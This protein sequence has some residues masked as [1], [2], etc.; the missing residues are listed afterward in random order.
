MPA[1]DICVASRSTM[2]NDIED[3]VSKLNAKARKAV[4]LTMIV[5]KDF[6]SQ[7]I[8]RYIGRDSVGFPNYIYA[9]NILHR[10]GYH[11]AVNFMDSRSCAVS[12]VQHT[13][14]DIIQAVQWS[15]GKLND[16]EICLLKQYIAEHRNQV[17]V[18][19]PRRRWAFVSWEK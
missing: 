4:Y 16:N 15:V 12:S 3:A 18:H 11:A 17:A 5:D 19:P 10:Q 6:I 2:V 13:E 1:C 9:V 14:Q 7:D 8:L